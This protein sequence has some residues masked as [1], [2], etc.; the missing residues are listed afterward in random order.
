V[1]DGEDGPRFAGF[2]STVEQAYSVRDAAGEYHETMAQGAFT[3]SLKNNDDVRLLVNHAGVPLART[4][5]GTLTLSEKPNLYAEARLDPVNPTVIE[6]RSAMARGDL[7][8]MSIGFRVVRQEWSKDWSERRILEAR[9]FDVSVVT[10]PA[11][12]YTSASLRSVAEIIGAIAEDIDE[13][14]LRRAIAHLETML[15]TTKGEEEVAIATAHALRMRQIALLD[16]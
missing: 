3:R 14:E 16:L 11:N 7:D 8:Q 9:L 12:P 15:P 5:S 6:V 2:A 10:E 4:K 1:R 13:Q